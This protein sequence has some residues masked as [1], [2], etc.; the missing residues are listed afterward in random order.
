[1]E[2]K[3]ITG[4]ERIKMTD[5]EKRDYLLEILE[6]HG[7]MIRRFYPDDTIECYCCAKGKTGD[8]GM[9]IRPR[10]ECILIDF[11][12]RDLFNAFDVSISNIEVNL[13]YIEFTYKCFA[14]KI[15]LADG[16]VFMEYEPEEIEE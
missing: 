13:E 6:A 7:W 10:V 5:K 1:M 8:V 15:R 9:L 2:L 4:I 3:D 12:I 11:W 16:H 14:M